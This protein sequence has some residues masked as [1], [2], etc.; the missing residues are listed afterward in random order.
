MTN[1]DRGN[2]PFKLIAVRFQINYLAYLKFLINYHHCSILNILHK[3]ATQQ[4]V[5]AAGKAGQ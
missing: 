5:I 1:N 3:I 4:K 2:N